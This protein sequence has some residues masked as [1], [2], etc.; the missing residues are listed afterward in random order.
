MTD[1]KLVIFDIDGTLIS[2]TG[3]RIEDSAVDAIQQLKDKGI[4][5]L[6]ATRPNDLFHQSARSRD[7]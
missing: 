5:V 6:I 1:I 7:R 2:E 4:K 3:N